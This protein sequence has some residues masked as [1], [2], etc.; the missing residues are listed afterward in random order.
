MEQFLGLPPDGSAHGPGIDQL[1]GL[2]HW[3]MVVLFVGWGTFYIFTLIRFRRAKNPNASY[4]GAKS[5]MSN[6][7]EVG[8]LL[9]EVTLLVGFSIP[10]WSQRVD[11]F[12]A[13]KEATLVRVVAEQFSWNV[14]YPGPDGKF[15]KASINLVDADNPLGLDRSDPDAKD[16]ITTINQLNLP[17]NKPV[18]IYLSSKDVIHSLNLPAYRVKQ[19][20]I[21]GMSIPVWFTP[22]KTT[23]EIQEE[24]KHPYSLAQA[25]QKVRKLA[26]P[27]MSKVVLKKGMKMD[28]MM[29]MQD[30][31]DTSGGMIISKGDHLTEENIGKLMDARTAEVAARP[32]ANLDKYVITEDAKDKDGNVVA[33]KNDPLSED[34]V[35]RL[36]QAGMNE[37]TGRPSSNMETFVVMQPYAD[38]SGAAI[39]Q[40]GDALSEEL[41]TKFLEAGINKVLLAPATP[42]EIACAQLCGLGHYRMRGFMTVQTAADFKQWFDQQEAAINPPAQPDSSA[43][44]AS[45]ASPNTQA[46]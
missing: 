29:V 22:V 45:A 36:V 19:D 7:L 11:K 34:A 26:L 6:Y 43:A 30:F 10:L 27:P 2:L 16:D 1:I 25:I 3:L 40:K 20:A 5:H 9:I 44:T 15:G 21:P 39:A 35:T 28:D 42:T 23:D 14:H 24:L 37:V 31:S 38:K 46:H 18:I 12:P 8:V 41:I 17:V 32:V 13:E 4:T 33:A